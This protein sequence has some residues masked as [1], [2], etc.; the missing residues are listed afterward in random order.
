MSSQLAAAEQLSECLLNQMTVLSIES[1]ERQ[2]N[3]RKELFETIGIPYDGASFSSPDA[4]KANDASSVKKLSSSLNSIANK[5]QSRRKQSS[6]MKNY[7]P[8]TARRR[9]DSLDRVIFSW[10]NYFICIFFLQFLE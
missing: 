9:R 4:T 10:I 5:D 2:Q 3:V 7:E 6:L 1:P 8:E